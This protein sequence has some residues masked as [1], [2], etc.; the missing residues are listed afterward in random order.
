MAEPK[1]SMLESAAA[2][3]AAGL[4]K[5]SDAAKKVVT[6]IERMNTVFEQ[7]SVTGNTFGND[8][9]K[10]QMAATN[11]RMPLKNLLNYYNLTMI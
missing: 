11:A 6:P 1:S 7:L 2:G 8:M 10:M 4:G 5:V 3:A 9:V